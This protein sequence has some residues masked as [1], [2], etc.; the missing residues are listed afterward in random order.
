ML[1]RRT[2]LQLAAGSM[3]AGSFRASAEARRIP[4]PIYRTIPGTGEAIPVIGMGTSVSFDKP[5][6]A[7]SLEQ[8]Q[9][10]TRAFFDNHGRVIDC[11]PMYGEAEARV[12][13][14]L[15]ALTDPSR[16]PPFAATKVWTYG[17]EEGI[18]QME[19][20]ARRMGVE[21][22]DLI[23]VHNLRDWQTQ[24]ATLRQW[25]D[26][27]RV[28]YIGITT[29]HGRS[30]GELLDIMRS[31]PLDFVQ[32]SYNL[33]DRE[34]ER[35]LLPLAA[36]RGIATMIN[37]PFQ[38]GALFS[39]ARGHEL[40]A[41]AREL[42]VSSWAQFFLKFIVGHPATTCVIPATSRMEHMIDNMQANYGAVP[43]QQQRQEM[44]QVFQSL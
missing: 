41:M 5:G 12:G 40:P 37:R 32:V 38:Q 43:D 36:E 28:R 6:D 11:S 30:H 31:E 19:E 34:A 9:Q 23:A 16:P 2:V 13:D 26:E 42:D 21:R 20:S 44:L 24:L 27:G 15:R 29:S 10:V 1:R 39:R 33:E 18:A 14:V 4:Q 25:Q 17:R 35:E 7:A 3:A 8:L 22:L